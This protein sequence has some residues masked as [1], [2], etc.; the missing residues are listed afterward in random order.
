VRLDP[1]SGAV[2]KRIAIDT[3]Y[4]IA[5]GAGDVWISGGPSAQLTRIDTVTNE[6]AATAK[7]SGFPGGI[8]FGNDAAW[9]SDPRQGLAWKVNRAGTVVG[10]Y[11]TGSGARG[12]SFSDGVMW[13]ANSDAGSVTGVDVVTGATQQYHLGHRIRGVVA[14]PELVAIVD[15][16]FED[17]VSLVPKGRVLTVSATDDFSGPPDPPT[18]AGPTWRQLAYTSCIS[19]VQYPDK[20]GP[21][22]LVL[23]PEAA[24]AMPVVSADGRTY[25][26]TIKSGF[27]F[28][29][30]SN[31]VV[32]AETFRFSLERV[33]SPG[34][35]AYSPAKDFMSGIVG[36]P[37]YMRGKAQHVAG[38]AASADK[39]TIR[40]VEPDPALLWKLALSYYCPVPLRTPVAR[41]GIDPD[42]PISAAGPYYLAKHADGWVIFRKNPN[43]H[44]GRPQPFE[45]IAVRFGLDPG[46]SVAKVSGGTFD[47][48]IESGYDPAQA[49]KPQGSVARQW[50]PD[51]DAAQQ[52]DQRWFGEP[53]FGADVLS[54][55]PGRPPFDD[56]NVRRAV[57]LAL[58][59]AD[60]VASNLQHAEV[61]SYT[62]LPPGVLGEIVQEPVPAPNAD[63]ARG[64][65]NKGTAEAVFAITPTTQCPSCLS[66][67]GRVAD[68]LVAIGFKVRII[69][70]DHRFAEAHKPGTPINMMFTRAVA[71][72][73]DPAL[74]LDEV[75]NASGWAGDARFAELEGIKHLTGRERLAGA[76]ALAKELSDADLTLP[77]GDLAD[78]TYLS[79][80][81]ACGF[82]QPG[83][84]AVDLLGLCPR[85]KG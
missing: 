85:V 80:N 82:V 55:N 48:M 32:T 17:D 70:V 79:D 37:E 45:A 22:G 68:E 47:V 13:I 46:E 40:L 83:I 7:L 38:L 58:D 14:G 6:L 81:V 5:F 25:S 11:K 35:D 75:M 64:L 62:P 56:V 52:G 76:A 19:L 42:P 28:S 57:A 84:A 69:Q 18:S 4:N 21:E 9:T 65:V 49:L 50:G 20:P 10:T 60:L 72:Y 77:V 2:E 27:R 29:P 73:P 24:T 8:G 78:S 39:L 41:G 61:P 12:P 3:A 31:E 67:A 59:R 74:I 43:Y 54:L 34:L 1:N 51:S 33:L 15:L 30:P 44:A 66:T 63:A 53:Q 23:Q 16:T 26:F 36:A 71:E